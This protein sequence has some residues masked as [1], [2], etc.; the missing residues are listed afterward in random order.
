VG[1]LGPDE[2]LSSLLE[3]ATKQPLTAVQLA[4]SLELLDAVRSGAHGT[5]GAHSTLR[6]WAVKKGGLRRLCH[7]RSS[8]GC[9]LSRTG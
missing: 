4:R 2:E 1:E 6:L 5:Q 9:A 8:C 7:V 3:A